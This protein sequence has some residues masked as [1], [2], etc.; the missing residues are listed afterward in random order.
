MVMV[1]MMMIMM[2]IMTMM[3]MTIVSV[4]QRPGWGEHV[5]IEFW[6]LISSIQG[7][8]T[9]SEL[10]GHCTCGNLQN[11]YQITYS[12]G[13]SHRAPN[14]I[15][16]KPLQTKDCAKMV[17]FADK[18]TSKKY[19]KY[20]T[21]MEYVILL[22]NYVCICIYI[23]TYILY[24]T[25]CVPHCLSRKRHLNLKYIHKTMCFRKTVVL[26]GFSLSLSLFPLSLSLSFVLFLS[27]TCICM[28]IYYIV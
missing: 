2:M 15:M 7:L 3:I 23:Y 22:V 5:F 4:E 13:H 14:L 27:D 11:V 26:E 20:K 9:A 18:T 6:T 1:M 12:S 28:I 8:C 19:S 16:C 21:P 25:P 17:K 10:R 24:R